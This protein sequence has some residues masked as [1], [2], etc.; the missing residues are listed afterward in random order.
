MLLFFGAGVRRMIG[1]DHIDKSLFHRPPQRLA[2]RRVANGRIHLS[3][4]SEALVTVGRR[5]C[6][7][8]RGCFDGGKLARIGKKRQFVRRRHMQHV[9]PAPGAPG[10]LQDALG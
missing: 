5:K 9:Q 2:M 4:G 8:L 1:A 10:E 6:E 7:M 3:I